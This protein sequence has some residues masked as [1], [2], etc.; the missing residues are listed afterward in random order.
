MIDIE[1]ELNSHVDISTKF[2]DDVPI[3][4][5]YGTF[6]LIRQSQLNTRS[7]MEIVCVRFDRS[8][9]G[10]GGTGLGRDERRM[11]RVQRSVVV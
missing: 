11:S 1:I 10:L 4:K 8:S 7:G 2:S 6:S 9:A 3:E 5:R